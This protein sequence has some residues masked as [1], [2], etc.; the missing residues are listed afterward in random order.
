MYQ[1]GLKGT[2]V[3]YANA[4]HTIHAVG[5][6]ISSVFE[7]FDVVMLSTLAQLPVPLGYMNTNAEDLTGYGEKLYGFMPNTQPFNV[8]GSP[9]MSV[10]LAW[11]DDGL[12]IG[13]M[14]AARNGDE[15]TLFRLAGQ[16][17]KARPWADK[18]PDEAP[19]RRR[20]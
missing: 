19:L 14:F 9:A 5:R 7:S 2:A 12:P 6:V 1:E 17:E 13:I 8:N 15:A 11:S 20:R 4:M 10:P 3:A 18:R 16:L